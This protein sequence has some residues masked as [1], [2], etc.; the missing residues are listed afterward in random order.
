[1]ADL[2]DAEAKQADN[3]VAATPAALKKEKTSPKTRKPK[4]R[5][6]SASRTKTSKVKNDTSS[7]PSIAVPTISNALRRNYTKQER[8][9]KLGEIQKLVS[10]GN[11]VKSATKTAGISEQTYYQWK[12]PDVKKPASDEL[13]DLVKLEA[14]NTRLKKL[15]AERLR[16]ENS[17]LKKKLAIS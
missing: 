8:A 9:Q 1:M 17:E 2:K 11:S 15:L 13:S 16:K 10:A 14:E 7:A 5:V 12:R 4:A 3:P 6:E